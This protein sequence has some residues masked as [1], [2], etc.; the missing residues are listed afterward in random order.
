MF[1]KIQH[2]G[3]L[4]EDIDAAVAWYEKTFGG[5]K[6]GGGEAE[7]GKLA[8]VRVGEAEVELI[9][10]ADRSQLTGGG[11]HVFHHIGYFLPDLDKAVADYKARGYKFAT[12]Q[13]WV[14]AA[15]YRLIFFDTS[16]TNGTRIHLT[17]SSTMK[18]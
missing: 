8:F 16:C 14:N 2:A 9:E 3:Y 12:E 4:V 18:W 13:P 17:D 10:P 15:G 11:D 7:M 1:R 5:A 6:I